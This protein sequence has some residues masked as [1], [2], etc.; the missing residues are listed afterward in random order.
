MIDPRINIIESRLKNIKKIIAVAG[1]KGGVGKSSV[2]SVLSLILSGQNFRVGLLDLDFYGPSCHFILGVKVKR[3]PDEEKGIIPPEVLGLKFMSIVY[4]SKDNPALFRGIDVSN[5]IIELLAVTLWD[6][7]DF[8]IIDMP[9]GIGD[10]TQDAIRL[11]NDVEFLLVT[12]PSKLA[13]DV[14]KKVVMVL[15][16]LKIPII[17]AIEN[18]KTN[19]TPPFKKKI[20]E[21]EIPYLGDIEFDQDLEQALGEREGI[22]DTGFAGNLSRIILNSD[23]F[24]T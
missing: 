17:G 16:E 19:H 6:R 24:K 8:L 5:S 13:L 4:Y 12:V 21:L 11:I 10:A 15:K 22:L 23:R 9:P 3:F 2:A 18:M 14:V 1:G 7:L 20:E